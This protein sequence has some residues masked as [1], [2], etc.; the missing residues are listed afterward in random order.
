KPCQLLT[1]SSGMD[2]GRVGA[3]LVCLAL[4]AAGCG[5]G[6]ADPAPTPDASNGALQPLTVSPAYYRRSGPQGNGQST[7]RIV[8][9]G[10][11]LSL[12][13]PAKLFGSA[14]RGGVKLAQD[15]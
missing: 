2:R 13:G 9:V 5:P 1:F 6:R 7:G 8:R 12:T 14:Q 3:L 11:A 4:L 10:A 15:E